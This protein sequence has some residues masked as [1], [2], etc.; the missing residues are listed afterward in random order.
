[1]NVENESSEFTQH[2]IPR[3]DGTNYADYLLSN[4]EVRCIAVDADNRKWMGTTN[5]GVYVISDDCNTEVQH[6]T[7]ENSPL[8]SNLIKDIIIMPNGLVYFATDQGLCSYMSDVTATNEEMTK[9]NVYA[10]PNPVKPDYTG[11]INIVGLSF[12]ADIKIVSVNGTLVKQG[13]STSG[14]YSWDGCDLKGRKVASGIYMVETATEEGEKGTV[15]KIAII[16]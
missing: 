9:G 10:Y 12:H 14:S 6:F 3:N 5:N 13:K 7:T 16:R 2:K 8:P 1:M 15:C 11:S 4:V